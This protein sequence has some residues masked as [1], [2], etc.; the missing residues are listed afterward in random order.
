[1]SVADNCPA[2]LGAKPTWTVQLLPLLSVDPQ[3]L[4][5][6]VKLAAFCPVVWNPTLL[7]G[8]PPVLLTASVRGEAACPIG[9]AVNVSCAGDTPIEG[10]CNPVP[11][12]ATVC[13]W[14]ASETRRLPF[15]IPAAFG[16]NTTLI[17]QLAW[18]VSCVPHVL[19]A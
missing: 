14:I 16:E 13:V 8:A 2:T 7:I 19:D 4:A 12:S 11:E 18:P 9:C 5:L 6:H 3:V 17:A 15:R 10:G 1:M